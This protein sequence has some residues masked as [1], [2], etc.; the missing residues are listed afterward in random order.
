MFLRQVPVR[1]DVQIDVPVWIEINHNVKWALSVLCGAIKAAT[2]QLYITP[3]ALHWL[4]LHQI[5]GRYFV[6]GSV[7]GCRTIINEWGM[8]IG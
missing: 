4:P 6:N 2:L 7:L 8:T 5:F 3:I 1:H